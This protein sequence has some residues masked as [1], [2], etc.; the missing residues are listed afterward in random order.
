MGKYTPSGYQIIKLQFDSPETVDE[1]S[2][3]KDLKDI[4]NY[5][6]QIVNNKG[7]FSKPL[8]LDINLTIDEVG[9]HL[10]G[11]PTIWSLLEDSIIYI[12]LM[13]DNNNYVTLHYDI[14]E[15]QLIIYGTIN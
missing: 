8:L 11:I 4:Y 14:S 3:R 15:D 7:E 5:L 10:C 1:F 6:K 12:K 13:Y 2:Q 9:L